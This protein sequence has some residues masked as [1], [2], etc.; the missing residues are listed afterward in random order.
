MGASNGFPSGDIDI[1]A[2]VD[3]ID[4]DASHILDII[5]PAARTAD[6]ASA[7]VGVCGAPPGR[8]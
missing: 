5:R 3:F 2:Y 7:V 4:R 6:R 8:S 1:S